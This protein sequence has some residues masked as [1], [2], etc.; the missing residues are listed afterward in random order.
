MFNLGLYLVE[1]STMDIE[2]GDLLYLLVILVTIG[3]SYGVIKTRQDSMEARINTLEEM[4]KQQI[5]V[6]NGIKDVLLELQVG[7]AQLT[8]QIKALLDRLNKVDQ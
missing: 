6:D 4:I 5:Q 3:V 2:I 1:N 8:E 7:Q